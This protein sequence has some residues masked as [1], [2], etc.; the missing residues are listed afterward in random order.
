MVPDSPDVREVLAGE[1]GVFDSAQPGTLVIDFSSIRPDVTAELAEQARGAGA[2]APRRAGVRRRGRRDRRGRCRSWSAARRRTSRTPGRCSTPSGKTIVHVGPS[3][4]GQTVKAANQLIVAGNIQVLAEAV[5]F[6]EAYGVDTAA[7][8]TVLGG[9][10]AGSKVL[11]QK[12]ANMLSRSFEPGLPDRPAP[13]GPRHRHLRRPRGRRGHPARRARR[14]ADGLRW[15]PTATAASTTPRCCAAWSGSPGATPTTYQARPP[16]PDPRHRREHRH[17][18]YALLDAAVEIL[19]RE[20]VEPAFGAARRG[21]QPVLPG[22]ARPRRHQAHP[23][24]PRR[25]R[26]AHGRGLHPRQGR[27]HRRLHRHLRPGRH[28]HDHRPVLGDRRLHPDP[29]HHRAGAGRQAAQGGLPGRRHRLDRPAAD[30]DG[31]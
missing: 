2:P 22:D 25:G 3:G 6:L 24:P 19:E 21:D 9:G 17:A 14:P 16:P 1:G 18:P 29:V 7:A 5:V 23:R 10:L 13:Q 30:Q 4:A 31:R 20:G 26:L 11:D 15:P 12:G 27:Q 28:R 8:L